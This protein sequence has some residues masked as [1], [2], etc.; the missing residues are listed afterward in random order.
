MIGAL[1]IRL[2]TERDRREWRVSSSGGVEP[3]NWIVGRRA[4]DV[5]RLVPLVF[6]LC[7][8]AHT[9]AA[10]AALGLTADDAI[11]RVE[12]AR[13]ERLRDHAVAIL[14]DWPVILGGTPDRSALK[15][16]AGG[17]MEARSALRRHLLGS[18][19]DLATSTAE[20]LDRW[21]QSGASRTARQLAHIRT[22]VE[23]GW[24]RAELATPEPGDIAA[25]LEAGA[26]ASPRETTAADLWRTTPL[27]AEIRE[28]EGASLFVRL[29]ARLLDLLAC[30]DVDPRAVA[31]E[32]PLPGRGIGLARAARGLLAHR[33]RVVAGIV[34][35]YRILSPSA[36]NLAEDGL[37]QCMLA[38]LPMNA[39]TPML[40]RLAVSCVN[41]CVPV[42]LRLGAMEEVGHA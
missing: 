6:N 40:A 5:V 21:L 24:G 11:H 30:L 2:E 37:L 36:W 28:R 7:A 25:A 16:L 39:Q 29:L 32:T 17:S 22:T 9:E 35:D 20:A 42:T 33:A 31:E 8:S 4:E 14:C 13:Q 27:L 12:A 34:T 23:P 10:R 26:P 18:E 3:A 1:D 19:I 38:A 41:P 15:G